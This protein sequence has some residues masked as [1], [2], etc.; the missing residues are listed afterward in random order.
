VR[1]ARLIAPGFLLAA[2]I[3]AA[4][5]GL[6]ALTLPFALAVGVEVPLAMLLGLL[7][8]NLGGA[9]VAAEPGVRF[10]V[11]FVLGAGI[12]LLGLRLN[13]QSVVLIGSQALLLIVATLVAV[14]LFAL[15]AGRRLGVPGR[16]AVLIG[17]GTTVCGNSAILAAAPVVRADERETSFALAAITICGTISVLV[18]PVAGHVLG[19][20]VLTF[21]LWSGAAVPDTAQ[22]IA[23]SAAY[24]T[25]GRDVATVVKLVRTLELAP[26]LLVLAWAWRHYGTDADVARSNTRRAVPF[27]L[28]GF[29]ALAGVRTARLLDPETLAGADAVARGCFVVA[30]AALGLQTR[31]AHV[32]AIGTRGVVLGAS[33]VLV[34]AGFSLAAI[35]ALGLGPARTQ[36]AGA[37]TPRPFPPTA[38]EAGAHRVTLD[39]RELATGLPG[40]GAVAPVGRF[41]PGGPVQDK[42]SFAAATRPGRVLAPDRLLVASGDAVLSLAT[43]AGGGPTRVFSGPGAEF[44]NTR[45]EETRGRPAVGDPRGI[46]MNNAF[47][48]PWVANGNGTESV[49]D[50]DGRPLDH[51]PSDR[52]GGVFPLPGPV[53][54][55][56]LLGAS[57]D[58]SGRAVFATATA[59]GALQQ[60]HVEDGAVP[61]APPGTIAPFPA[62]G[63]VGIAFN[64]VPERILYVTDPRRD[65]IVQLQ[66]DDDFHVFRVTR[67]RRLRSPAF[68]EPVDLAPAVPEVVSPAFASNTTLAG[69]ADLYVANRGTGT[70]VRLT[71]DGHIR[72]VARV[73]LPDGTLVGPGELAG[74]ATAPDARR[75][76]LTVGDAVLS[77]PAFR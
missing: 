73:R 10:T 31:V 74:L 64:W 51:A 5:H 40:A 50:P 75:L 48:R 71:Q 61:L 76:W 77:V 26:L 30:L 1:A 58:A 69:G 70:I 22:T 24:S 52:F 41:L 39:A 53:M 55:N 8:A 20:D 17:I 56:A 15:L 47:G 23:A 36:V 68:A 13:M 49:L 66:L 27:F 6:A 32:R 35:T 3:G 46:S 45:G 34:S 57:P 60:V 29:C 11:R 38:A 9:G 2:A 63:R 72:A 37:L 16:V 28:V 44:A 14:T 4:A 54:G 7:V 12:V 67:T 19:L 33:T 65:A 59:D 18:L 62:G 21:G 25:V 43:R 42:R